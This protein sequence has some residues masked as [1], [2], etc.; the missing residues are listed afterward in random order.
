MEV[1]LESNPSVENAHPLVYNATQNQ[2]PQ[3]KSYVLNVNKTI[4]F[5]KVN[6]IVNAHYQQDYN[7]H[8][9]MESIA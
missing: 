5:S 9:L 4:T 6:A 3:L 7:I 2:G 1:R 8:K